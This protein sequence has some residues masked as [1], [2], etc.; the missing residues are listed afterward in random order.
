MKFKLFSI[1]LI[2]IY[3]LLFLC[4][5]TTALYDF[6]ATLYDFDTKEPLNDVKVEYEEMGK[7]KHTTT[8]SKGYFKVSVEI[9]KDFGGPILYKPFCFTKD[10][11]EHGCDGIKEGEIDHKIY[12]KKDTTSD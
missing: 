5:S 12:W 3:F 2:F 9:P 1:I 6:G 4:C 10:G 8:N 7:T 11:Y